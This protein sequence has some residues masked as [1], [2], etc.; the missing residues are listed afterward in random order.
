MKQSIRSVSNSIRGALAIAA[1]SLILGGCASSPSTY[2]N[3]DQS[4]DFQQYQTYAFMQELAT[5]DNQYQSLDS[6]YL[7]NSVEKAMEA[8]GFKKSENPDI[9]INFSIA[10]QEKIRSRSAPATGI[11]AGF[12]DPLY[13]YDYGYGFGTQTH[14]DQYTEGKLTIVAVDTASNQLVWEGS[15]A[16]R[17]TKKVKQNWQLTLEDAVIEVFEGFPAD[18]GNRG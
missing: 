5:D 1:A 6:T 18:S 16:G 17:L 2:S 13:G 15:T 3:A 4:V 8:R 12:Y 7:K 9:V 14:I 10:S 11:H